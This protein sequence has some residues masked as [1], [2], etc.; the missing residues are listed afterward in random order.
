[1]VVDVV[2]RDGG[3]AVPHDVGDLVDQR[4]MGLGD[5]ADPLRQ[6]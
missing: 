5:R 3:A 4:G 6:H 1:M 2:D